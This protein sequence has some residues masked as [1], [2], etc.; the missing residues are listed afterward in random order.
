MVCEIIFRFSIEYIRNE[1]SYLLEINSETIITLL[2]GFCVVGVV[3]DV[4][5]MK[6]IRDLKR[7][8]LFLTYS[9]TNLLE[10][11]RCVRDDHAIEHLRWRDLASCYFGP[12]Y[13]T[14]INRFL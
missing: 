10:K 5:F 2:V 4:Y 11:I 7:K 14:L 3:P 13:E 9:F 8:C 6:T 1:K 12:R